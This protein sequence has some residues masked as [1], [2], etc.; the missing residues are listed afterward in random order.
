MSHIIEAYHACISHVKY[1]W[2]ISRMNEA[3]H[4]PS[5]SF[6]TANAGNALEM[7]IHIYRIW[8]ISIYAYG[9]TYICMYIYIHVSKCVL[10]CV[11]V[12][13]CVHGDCYSCTPTNSRARVYI[14][15][16][17]QICTYILYILYC[18]YMNIHTNYVYCTY[19]HMYTS[20]SWVYYM[21]IHVYVYKY[22]CTYYIREYICTYIF[23]YV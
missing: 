9:D 6:S 20:K 22:I 12:C 17:L 5:E 18:M 2:A 13:V 14:S 23:V 10:V 8:Y 19:M 3:C 4:H 11:C 21:C 16:S 15:Y 7:G 1:I